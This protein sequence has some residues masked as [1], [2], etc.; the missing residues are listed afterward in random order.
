M[1]S[2]RRVSLAIVGLGLAGLVSGFAP[3]PE[4]GSARE[5]REPKSIV[6]RAER[7]A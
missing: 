7:G 3:S 6:G 2:K 1:L 5:V 4:I